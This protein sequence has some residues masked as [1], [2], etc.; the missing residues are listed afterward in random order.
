MMWK[1]IFEVMKNLTALLLGFLLLAL[2]VDVHS[3]KLEYDII[4]LGKIG[5]LHINKTNKEAYSFIETNSEVKLPFYKLNWITTTTFMDGQLQSSNYAQ[6]LNNKKRE[7]TDIDIVAENEWQIVNDD[8]QREVIDIRHNFNVSNLY[9]EEPVNETY[10]FSE[11][12][13]KPFELVNKGNG[14]Y[15]LLLPDKN[16]CDYFY[17][18]GICTNVKVKNGGRTIKF[19]L[20]DNG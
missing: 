19:V 6:L 20:N 15:R 1:T 4:W 3:Q 5:K 16:Y 17:E 7:Y 18:E 2:C 14:H 8:G 13:G 12:F 10:I 9:Y 11:R